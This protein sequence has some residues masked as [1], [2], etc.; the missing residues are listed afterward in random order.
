ML[1]AAPTM[2][3]IN[4]LS[5]IILASSFA[6][7]SSGLF[8]VSLIMRAHFQNAA[9]M[10]AKYGPNNGFGWRLNETVAIQSLTVPAANELRETGEIAM[11]LVSGLLIVFLASYVALT[12][13]IDSFLVR[14]LQEL[15]LAAEAASVTS[16][17]RMP[18]PRSGATEIHT[19]ASAIDR[20]RTS[21]SKA[22]KRISGDAPKAQA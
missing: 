2:Q 13:S 14:P 8:R 5:W 6:H 12:L 4:R 10:I 11:I 20:L 9:A 19:I 7:S 18:L 1:S 3:N 22:L 15:A 21:L 17:V 16:D